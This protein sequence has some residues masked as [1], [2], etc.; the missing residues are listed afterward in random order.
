L[1]PHAT[2]AEKNGKEVRLPAE[3]VIL[4]VGV[5]PDRELAEAL[6]E[7]G[8]EFYVVGDAAEP[9]GAGEAIWEGFGI[10]ASV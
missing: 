4:A 3:T 9:R 6:A 1:N 8:L 7:S 10:G 2:I 5:R